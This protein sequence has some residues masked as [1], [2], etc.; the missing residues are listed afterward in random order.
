MLAL[1]LTAVGP[2]GGA[3][4]TASAKPTKKAVA[5]TGPDCGTTIYKSDGSAWACTLA[6]GLDGT[7]LDST[8]WSAFTT[9]LTG[10]GAGSTE[11]RVDSPN[12]ISVH[13]GSLHL[14]ARKE[15]APF[16]CVLP[17]TS[18]VGGGYP[19][20]YTTG[21]VTT[22][23]KF[24]QTYGRFEIR[25]ALP[26]VSGAPH[27]C[28]APPIGTGSCSWLGDEGGTPGLHSAIWLY[29]EPDPRNSDSKAEIDIMER[30]SYQP[31]RAVPTVHY[32]GDSAD[33]TITNWQCRIGN[34]WDFHTYAV[35]WNTETITFIY[36]G[37]VCL[38]NNWQP[39]AP[40]VKP[41]PFNTPFFINL[42]QSLG[43][44]ANAYV[45][46]VTPLPATMKVDYV[47]VWS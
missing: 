8:Y 29:Y 45:E 15:P 37:Q 32:N 40:A 30:R 35:E 31:D 3:G 19:T 2:L 5:L 33:P 18:G 17:Y 1:V 42:N 27:L 41:A 47:K 23:R 46:G 6:D 12:N 4:S 28:P 10:T 25:A 11:C 13:D 26:D 7:D 24:N 44:N 22:A 16:I 39:A 43:I 20:Q 9:R 36:D 34:I 21:A 14:T 38:V